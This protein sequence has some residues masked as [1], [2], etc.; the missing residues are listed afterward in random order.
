MHAGMIYEVKIGSFGVRLNEFN[1]VFIVGRLL[2]VVCRRLL[3]VQMLK[4]RDSSPSAANYESAA[5]LLPVAT[6]VLE[7]AHCL[8]WTGGLGGRRET[9]G[10]RRTIA[11]RPAA[12][13][14]A[15]CAADH[16]ASRVDSLHLGAN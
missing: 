13:G 1:W 7:Q 14:A 8:A 9:V 5:L 12:S 2:S 3:M 15:R 10:W 4:S 6:V 16:H 11:R